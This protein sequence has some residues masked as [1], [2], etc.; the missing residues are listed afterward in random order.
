[1]RRVFRR[2]VRRVNTTEWSIS[3]FDALPG[4]DEY[5]L[6]GRFEVDLPGQKPEDL[7]GKEH[8]ELDDQEAQHT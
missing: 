6:A 1:M 4:E 7:P 5:L 3:W 2:L 8:S